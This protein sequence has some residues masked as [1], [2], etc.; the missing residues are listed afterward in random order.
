MKSGHLVKGGVVVAVVYGFSDDAELADGTV[1]VEGAPESRRVGDA[2][3]TGEDVAARIMA[4]L[5][6]IDAKS[7]R[8]LRAI[9]AAQ[10]SGM[11]PDPADISF[12]SQLKDQADALR[13]T[14]RGPASA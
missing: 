10:A 6:A 8:P 3:S 7:V 11:P 12:L 1:F 13:K 9:L 4:Q 5:D 14:I 2:Y